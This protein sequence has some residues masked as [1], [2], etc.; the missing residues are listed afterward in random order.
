MNT[1]P[2]TSPRDPELDTVCDL[3]LTLPVQHDPATVLS[4]LPD[5]LQIESVTA[6]RLCCDT[7]PETTFMTQLTALLHP[8]NVALILA[9]TSTILLPSLPL[10]KIDG[11]H[12][13]SSHELKALS[14]IH[15]TKRNNLQIGCSCTT[16]DDAMH[17]GEHGADYV[18]FPAEETLAITQW[19]FMAELPSVADS[20]TNQETAQEAIDAGA[21][22]LGIPLTLDGQDLARISTLQTLLT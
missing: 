10:D 1:H 22:F 2:T 7:A 18:A 5:I 8:H 4:T 11:L 20:V 15:S 16:L 9:P 6:L 13:P 21:D 14:N 19:S 12:L 3:Y 17:A